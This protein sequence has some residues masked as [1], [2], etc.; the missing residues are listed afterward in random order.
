ME[1]G[2]APVRDQRLRAG[3]HVPAR[4]ARECAARA[5]AGSSTSARWAAGWS[6]RAAAPTTAPS[7]RWRRSRTRCA[8]RSRGFGIDVVLIEP[9]LIKTELRRDRRGSIDAASRRRRRPV[10]RVQRH[11]RRGHRRRLRGPAA[12]AWA[13]ARRRSRRRSSEAISA[14][15]PKTR[16]KV[17]PSARLILVQRRLLTDRAWDAFLR[18]QFPTPR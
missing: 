9:G 7:T 14:R 10:R 18:T 13:A 6:S 3:A 4:P 17:T 12:R 5:R 1:R 8:S 11:R 2:P 15:R 16:Y